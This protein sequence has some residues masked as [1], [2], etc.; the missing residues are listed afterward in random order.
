MELRARGVVRHAGE[1]RGLCEPEIGNVIAS[2]ARALVGRS[3]LVG[4]L[5][6]WTGGEPVE[7]GVSGDRQIRPRDVSIRAR[8]GSAGSLLTESVGR[9]A[10]FRIAAIPGRLRGRC[11]V[12]LEVVAPVEAI[13]AHIGDL[14]WLATVAAMAIDDE[15]LARSVLPVDAGPAEDG[16]LADLTPR[17]RQVLGLLSEGCTN[18][19]IAERLGISR[20]TVRTH[21]QNI[22]TKLDVGT[23]LEAAALVL[24]T[25]SGG[26]ASDALGA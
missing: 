10:G 11:V 21:V 22:R 26:P 15:G 18:E 20:N 19:R 3:C 24:R 13:D 25:G 23:R 4:R 7:V 12:V 14:S 8:A 2:S 9:P 1:G 6:E 16:R 17:E 5:F